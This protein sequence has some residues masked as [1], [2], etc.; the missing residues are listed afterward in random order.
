[1]IKKMILVLVLLSSSVAYA[2]DPYVKTF[3]KGKNWTV[4]EVGITGEFKAVCDEVF[5]ELP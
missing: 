4:L 3:N 5:T 1:M 2:G